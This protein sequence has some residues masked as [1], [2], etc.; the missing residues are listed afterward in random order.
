MRESVRQIPN[1][2]L[3]GDSGENNPVGFGHI[4]TI[5]ERSSLHDWEI[6][7]HRHHYSVQ[8]LLV[9]E[10]E[11]E[12]SLDDMAT[13][14]AGPCHVAIPAGS[15]HGFRFVPGTR[16]HVLTLGQEFAR[17]VEGKDDPLA[18]LL[19]QG[20]HG[21]LSEEQARRVTLLADELLVL[22]QAWNGANGLFRAL[23]EALLRSLPITPA[24]DQSCGDRRLAQFRDL[25]ERHLAEHRP[26]SFYAASIGTTQR[27]LA[28]LVQHR[29]DCTPLEAINRR[30]AL[31]A[32]RLLR[33]TNASVAQVADELGF[34]D[35]SY[36]SRFYLRMTGSRPAAERG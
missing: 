10:G 12:V 21:P 23:A 29:L 5:A 8:V 4:E 24:G 11:V 7:P 35:P 34:T 20:G 30:L 6:A 28:R 14:Q 33:Y 13:R 9:S 17:R 3:Y 36:F 27:T 19:A 31:E 18:D 26:I 2:S 22:A 16:G 25:V 1:Y 32:R 15:V